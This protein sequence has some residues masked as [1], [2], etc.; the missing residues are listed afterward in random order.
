MG[1][2]EYLNAVEAKVD[3]YGVAIQTVVPE[4]PDSDGAGWGYTVGLFEVG[5]PEFL[6]SGFPR[7][8]ATPFLNDMASAVLKSGMRFD[9]GKRV[10]GLVQ[11]G[12]VW[13]THVANTHETLGVAHEILGRKHPNRHD[14]E[15][16]A[17]QVVFPDANDRWPWQEDYGLQAA[18]LFG[19]VP[20]GRLDLK[21]PAAEVRRS[22]GW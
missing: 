4:S 10:R 12:Y 19:P 17:L 6:I 18:T 16:S 11:H 14:A 22:Q 1:K 8:I 3:Q 21:L 7:E 13:L 5:H 9:T 20:Q 15:L 2:E